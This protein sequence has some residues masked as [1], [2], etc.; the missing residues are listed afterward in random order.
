MNEQVKKWLF[1]GLCFTA[2]IMATMIGGFVLGGV[3][4]GL[5]VS[6][7][8]WMSISKLPNKVKSWMGKHPIITDLVFLKLSAAVFALIGGGPTMFMAL[9]TQAIVLGLLLKNFETPNLNGNIQ[10]Q[11]AV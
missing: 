10:S 9:A 1:P 8:L 5:V 11:P 3:F 4:M 2:V 7:G 6:I